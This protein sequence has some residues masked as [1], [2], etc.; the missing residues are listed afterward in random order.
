MS[1]FVYAEGSRQAEE[2]RLAAKHFHVASNT[3][4]SGAVRKQ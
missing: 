4:S 2:W 3:I 1:G